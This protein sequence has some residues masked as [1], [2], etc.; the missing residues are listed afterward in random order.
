MAF[1][2]EKFVPRGGPSGGDGGSGGSV[3]LE[4]DANVHTLMDLRYNRHHFAPNGSPGEGSRRSGKDGD[5]LVLRVPAGT[6]ARALDG[7]AVLGEIRSAGDR[8]VLARGGRGGRGNA[9][10]K[11]P[12]NQAPRRSQPGEPGQE[13]RVALELRLLA[14]V[15]LVGLPNAGKS[16]LV[17][18][19]SAA[20]PKIA[21]YPFTTLVPTPGVVYVEEYSSF[22]IAD[23]PGIIKGAHKGKGLGLRFLK[24]IERNS[25]LL[26]VIPVTSTNVRVEYDTLLGELSAFDAKVLSKPRCI[27]F[28]KAD[29]LPE[30]E[31]TVW[32]NSRRALFSD[33]RAV[34]LCSA[35]AGYGIDSL[36]R[37]LWSL[38]EQ[39]RRV[40]TQPD[41]GG[42]GT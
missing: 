27:V 23:I 12:T 28:T 1:R 35:V 41:R 37:S 38:V 11:S 18:S 20:R 9:F 6:T 21:D 42:H 3:V 14:D 2:R 33:T 7:G 5:D 8:L 16:T 29:L 13:Q 34:M 32:L 39:E 24:H 15:G 4:G 31:R 36:K 25:V 26:F 30:S 17:S 22:V 40:Q 10:F 19:V